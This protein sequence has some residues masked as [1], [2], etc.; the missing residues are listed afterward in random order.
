MNKIPDFCDMML[1]PCGGVAYYDEERFGVNYFCGQCEAMLGSD[2]Q[3]LKCKAEEAKWHL[4]KLL[5][6][7]GWDYF[8]ELGEWD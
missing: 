4:Q 2:Q 8:Q 7:S 5:G 6:G 1:M 3:P